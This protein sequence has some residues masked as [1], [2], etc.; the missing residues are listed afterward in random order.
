M[1]LRTDAVSFN[2]AIGPAEI[3]SIDWRD[4][5][6]QPGQRPEDIE[7]HVHTYHTFQTLEGLGGSFNEIGWNALASLD[8]DKRKEVIGKLFGPSPDSAFTFCR[9][10]IGASDFATD[11]YSLDD[12]AGDYTMEHFTVERDEKGLIPYIKAAQAENPKLKI[13]ASPWSPP[14]WM[15]TSGKM[16]GG[17]GL[18][19]DEERIYRAYA[20]YF[21]RFIEEYEARG[22]PIDRVMVQN[23]PDANSSFPN[24]HMEPETLIK[25]T[26]DYLAPE[27][28]NAGLNSIWGGT[29]RGITGLQSHRCM[30]DTRYRETVGGVGFQYA[31]AGDIQELTQLYPGTPVMHTESVCWR[32][33]N[34]DLQA[35][36]LFLDF[37]DHMKAGCTAYTY[38]N[39]ILDETSSSSWSWS[40]N[41]LIQIDRN[42]GEVTYHPDFQVMN[43]LGSCLKLGTKRVESFCFAA[44]SIAFQNPD[45]EVVIFVLNPGDEREAVFE[46]DGRSAKQLIPA[47]SIVVV[48]L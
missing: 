34:S 20:L 1:T 12:T 7:V 6:N 45:G 43:L 5:K 48:T 13:H 4:K 16:D 3:L 21:R 32:G 29:F 8:E 25:F 17:D 27:L 15:K 41:S 42:S 47:R 26:V 30:A 18:L 33:E 19:I 36:A 11:A 31:F 40:Q 37:V 24:C 2:D 35:A 9:M 38:W 23:E 44:R 10:P 39:M 28:K 22:I 14:G 46:V